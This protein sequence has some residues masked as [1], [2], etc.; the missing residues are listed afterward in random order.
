MLAAFTILGHENS[1]ALDDS[2]EMTPTER[3]TAYYDYVASIDTIHPGSTDAN[4]MQ[5]ALADAREYEDYLEQQEL[6][7]EEELAA[8]NEKYGK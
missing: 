1:L 4:E 6:E 7:Y 8:L 2:D 3:V 5:I